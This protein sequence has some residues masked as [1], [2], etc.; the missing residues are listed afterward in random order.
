[1]S[2]VKR[3]I[4]S[5]QR[6]LARYVVLLVAM[7]VGAILAAIGAAHAQTAPFKK[8]VTIDLIAERDSVTPGEEIWIALRERI[9]PGWHTYWTNPGDS[10]ETTTVT[11]KLPAGVTAGPLQFPA[12]HA[13]PVGPLVNYGYSDQVIL[14][15]RLKIPNDAKAGPIDITASAEWLVCKD[16]CVPES[17]EAKLALTIP[18]P[19]FISRPKRTLE[20]M[21]LAAAAELPKPAPWPVRFTASADTVGLTFTGLGKGITRPVAVMF[22]PEAWGQLNHAGAQA[23]SWAGD[24]LTL[25]IERGD[26]K[27]EALPGLTG[28]LVLENA[29]SA[30]V[31]RRAYS[32]IAGAPAAK[33]V[34]PATVPAP[35]A[36]KTTTQPLTPPP[37]ERTGLLK[38]LLFAV[39]GGLILNLM[40][41]V[42]PVL[43]LKAV[44]LAQQDRSQAERRGDG[45]AYLAG[46]LASFAILAITLL[47][48]RKAGQSFG[49][50]FQFQ[51]PIFV[52]VMAGLFFTLGLLLSGIVTVGGSLVGAGEKLAQKSGFAGTFFTGALATIAATPCTAPFMGAAVGYALTAS[53][54]AGFLVLMAMGLGFAAPVVA[55]ATAPT[56]QRL[57]PK[58][59]RWMETFK[60]VMAFPLYASAAWMVWVLSVQSG[61]D[62]VLAAMTLLIGLGFLAWSWTWAQQTGRAVPVIV[63]A[64]ATLML[65]GFAA[66]QID[67]SAGRA[68]STSASGIMSTDITGLPIIPFSAETIAALQQEGRPVFV[69][70]TAAWC[71]T[72]KVNEKI[73]LSSEKMRVTLTAAKV[74]Y[75]KGDWTRQDPE[76]SRF[77][78]S[79][80]RAGVPLYLFYPPKPGAPPRILDQVL[81]EAHVLAELQAI[82]SVR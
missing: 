4:L 8:H 13:I 55:L 67:S 35:L 17:G 68:R 20:S 16:I 50:G 31:S 65:T 45:L 32:V 62:G 11:W 53:A 80:G 36:A 78:Q 42:F 39:L 34:A 77:L 40:P 79:F 7:L 12:P 25:R 33:A 54:F 73:A 6:L 23:I 26:L 56:L 3:K 43:S 24:D 69:N 18:E 44:A 2:T 51:S 74:A 61:S 37:T 46:V 76:I 52:L 57:M 66:S 41:C 29:P 19:G 58:P 60:Q 30:G 5:G 1:M 21:L 81:T 22:F 49:W 28:L 14:L 71:I 38:A 27:K 48:L 59:G 63:F 9:E 70:L 75:V 47:A 82:T 64:F 15:S 72:C 10:G